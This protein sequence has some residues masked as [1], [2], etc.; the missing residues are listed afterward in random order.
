MTKFVR[1]ILSDEAEEVYKYLIKQSENSKIER[2]ILNSFNKKKEL[3]KLNPRYG[4]SIK[5]KIIPKEYIN[6][7][8]VDN[9]FRVELPNFWRML[10]SLTENESKV[11]IIAFVIDII[12]HKVYNKKF[13]YK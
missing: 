12:D 1:V 9:L 6:K 8:E 3:I 2:S 10:Y 13:G 11:E 5:K 7:Y 4:V